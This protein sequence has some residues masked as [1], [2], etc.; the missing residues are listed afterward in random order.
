MRL[1]MPRFS[2]RTLVIVILLSGSLVALYLRG[3]M[4]HKVMVVS[5]GYR[6][7]YDTLLLV[8]RTA[9]ANVRRSF[10]IAYPVFTGPRGE[11]MSQEE[12]HRNLGYQG[13][14][15][16]GNEE[17]DVVL[18]IYVWRRGRRG[19]PVVSWS[20]P[21]TEAWTTPD[22]ESIV[23]WRRQGWRGMMLWLESWATALF[24]G[25][26]VWSVW[27]DRKALGSGEDAA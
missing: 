10:Q 21:H 22:G 5:G 17:W 20:Y 4:W 13:A 9:S 14:K 2:L 11:P 7:G 26:L 15:V 3:T 27:R 19:A 6:D 8:R 18:Y 16:M 1:P 25:L 12:G 23:L 24:A